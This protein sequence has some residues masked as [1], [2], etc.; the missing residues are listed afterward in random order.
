MLTS[1]PYFEPNHLVSVAVPSAASIA[2]LG[3]SQSSARPPRLEAASP[4]AFSL[5]LYA[6]DVLVQALA[7]GKTIDATA[8][9]A[10][11]LMDAAKGAAGAVTLMV[12]QTTRVASLQHPHTWPRG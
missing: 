10:A 12:L 6:G 11:Q 3:L 8:M 5:G 2:E 7:D 1:Q 9:D 4:L